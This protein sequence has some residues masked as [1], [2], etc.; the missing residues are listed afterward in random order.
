MHRLWG[1]GKADLHF[2]T[3]QWKFYSEELHSI[4]IFIRHCPALLTS[5]WKLVLANLSTLVFGRLMWLMVLVS[6][7]HKGRSTHSSMYKDLCWLIHASIC[8][9]YLQT[10]QPESLTS[11]L[12]HLFLFTMLVPI[13]CNNYPWSQWSGKEWKPNQRKFFSYISRVFMWI[14]MAQSPKQIKTGNSKS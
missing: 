2:R 7:C 6:V 1:F 10:E 14:M 9:V 8:L 11:A 5:G 3:R 12:R 4:H 13:K